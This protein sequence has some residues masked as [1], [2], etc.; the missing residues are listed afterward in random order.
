LI[1]DSA[2]FAEPLAG[3]G[4]GSPWADKQL[5][6]RT[7]YTGTAKTV[8]WFMAILWIAIWVIGFVAVH[9]RE[10][11][12]Q[13]FQLTFLHKALA[14][15]ILILTVL[16]VL[17]RWG[18]PAPAMPDTMS[19]F[20]QRAAHFGHLAIYVLALVAL[21]LSGWYWSSVADKA[22]VMLGLIHIP[23]LVAPAPSLYTTAKGIHTLIAWCCGLMISGHILVA[24]KHH[25]VDKDTVLRQMLPHRR[26]P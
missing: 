15:T 4:V 11:Y 12:N 14:S 2:F 5:N 19:A 26:R 24:L 8:H 17:W 9:W 7:S 6:T 20:M 16:R 25:L 3:L 18:H 10:V 21:P 1:N 13:H 23:P 22:V